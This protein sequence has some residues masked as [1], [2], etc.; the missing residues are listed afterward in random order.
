MRH[1]AGLSLLILI[2]VTMT[3]GLAAGSPDPAP[4]LT[5]Y[6]LLYQRGNVAIQLESSA[7]IALVGDVSMARGVARVIADQGDYNYPLAQVAPLLHTADLAVGNYE[8]VIAPD[9]VGTARTG[10]YR[11][12][13]DPR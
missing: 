13:A 3:P 9:G 4:D 10:G 2:L 8:G 12:R 7:Q 11:L 5:L 6:P 1:I